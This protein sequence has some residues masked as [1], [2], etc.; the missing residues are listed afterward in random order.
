MRERYLTS[1]GGTIT[2]WWSGGKKGTEKMEVNMGYD[3][4][5]SRRTEK[6]QGGQR[7]EGVP[8]STLI[9]SGRE[10][11]SPPLRREDKQRFTDRTT[12]RSQ[13]G[14][15]RWLR[16]VSNKKWLKSWPARP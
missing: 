12:K 13:Q 7:E 1:G 15:V 6:V 16:K 11:E 9:C 3:M 5:L 14:E 8:A 10:L 2:F 4:I